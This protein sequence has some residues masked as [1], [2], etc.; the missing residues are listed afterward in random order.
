MTA[1]YEF[2]LKGRRH[3]AKPYHFK[4]SGLPNVYLLS[5]VRIERDADYG[6]LVTI[7]HLPDLVM[8]VAFRL[9]SKPDRMTGAEMRYLCKRMGVTQ[10]DLAKEL[11][12]N[13][14]TIAN[15]EK[16]KTE[17]GP[18]DRAL[19]LL[20][21]AHVVDDDAVAEELCLEAETRMRPSQQHRRA[22]RAGR[23]LVAA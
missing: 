23:W 12:V 13:E 7:D 16:G 3:L 8:A 15:Y 19:R 18:A 17:P 2:A 1:R 5:G 20:F 4:A 9:V 11:W 6:E 14:Q 22:P 21:L 10:A